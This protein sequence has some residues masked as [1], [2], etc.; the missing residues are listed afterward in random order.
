MPKVKKSSTLCVLPWI[1][2]NVWPSGS[3]TPCCTTPYDDPVGNVYENTLDQIA[4]SEGMNLIRRQMLDGE[5]PTKCTACF[6]S[7][8]HGGLSHRLYMNGVFENHLSKIAATNADGSIEKFEMVYW[9]VRFSNICNFRC[10]SCSAIL[11]SSWHSDSVKIGKTDPG[12]KSVIAINE[13]AGMWAQLMEHVPYVEEVYLIGGEPLLEKQQ[14]KLIELL[15][16]KGLQSKV[17]LR[18]NTNLSSLN[19]QGHDVLAVWKEFKTVEVIVSLDGLGARGEYI[20]KGMNWEIVKSN[21]QKIR[22]QGHVKIWVSFLSSILNAYHFSDF[23]FEVLATGLIQ[24]DELIFN[25][26]YGPADYSITVLPPALK[27]EVKVCYHKLVDDLKALNRWELGSF[28]SR[29]RA[30]LA[31]M[32]A[33]DDSHLLPEFLEATEKLDALR[34]E[35]F[36]D[37]FPEYQ[38]LVSGR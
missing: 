11:S 14:W 3:V 23:A 20:R 28:E 31:Y 13:S 6:K 15:R 26:L 16:S 35:S 29:V 33:S 21:L 32:D 37:V 5:R 27:S 38:C 4:K 10:R 9:D 19:T 18:Y 36:V 34:G 30:L 17:K 7:E 12:Q 8:D 2:L 1:H 25:P 24:P 22:E